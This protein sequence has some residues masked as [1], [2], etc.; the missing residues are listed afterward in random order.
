MVASV[1]NTVLGI[2]TDAMMDAGLLQE[3]ADPNSE[4]LSNYMRRLCD[5]INLWQT[6]G[7]KLF[8]QADLSITL[9][10]AQYLYE[11]GP[12]GDLDM[13]KPLRVLNAYV[14]NSSSVKRNLVIISRDDYT[15]LS[16]VSGNDG[17]ISQCFIDKQKA[18]INVYV[19]PPPDS[20]DAANTLH[21]IAQ[22]QVTDPINLEED[23]AFPQEWRI[24]LRWALA[25][26]ICTG[27]PQAIMDRC[28]DRAETYKRML[29]DWD[30]EDVSTSFAPDMQGYMSRSFS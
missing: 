3:G 9:V 17:T 13:T 23:M 15:R 24:A 2:I 16:Q 6:Q 30:V 14:L 1:S 18:T 12:G 25:D 29:E 10:T 22:N 7:I 20:T 27:Q 8:L 5:I 26:D 11:V 19:W 21:V 4:Q 28:S